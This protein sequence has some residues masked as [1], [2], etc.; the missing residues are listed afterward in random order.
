MIVFFHVFVTHTF[1]KAKIECLIDVDFIITG[2]FVSSRISSLNGEI[3]FIFPDESSFILI[4]YNIH[5][6]EFS[7]AY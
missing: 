1:R 5:Y 3:I 4:N 6:K 7:R 2:Y